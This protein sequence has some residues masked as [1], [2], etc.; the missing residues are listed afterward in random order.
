ML[1][2]LRVVSGPPVVIIGRVAS[3]LPITFARASCFALSLMLAKTPFLGCDAAALG[4]DAATLGFDE[5]AEVLALPPPPAPEIGASDQATE[6]RRGDSAR[7]SRVSS[8]TE[9]VVKPPRELENAWTVRSVRA[10]A[11]R[12]LLPS[13][14]DVGGLVNAA[15]EAIIFAAEIGFFFRVG[16]EDVEVETAG[17]FVMVDLGR[18]RGLLILVCAFLPSSS[19]TK[20]ALPPPS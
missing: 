16:I 8:S 18:G 4:F 14:G 13:I 1:M 11:V 20:P 19:V 15:D 5:L 17:G 9:G 10:R 2:M 12:N 3:R 6:E 7:Q